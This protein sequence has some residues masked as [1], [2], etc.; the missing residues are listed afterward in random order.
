MKIRF[1]SIVLFGVLHGVCFSDTPG[2]PRAVFVEKTFNFGNVKQGVEVTHKF[3]VKNEG[4]AP[5]LLDRIDFDLPGLTAKFKPEIPPGG[6][7]FIQVDWNTTSFS[8]PIDLE[9]KLSS[10]DPVRPK[11]TFTL[12]GSI[13][14]VIEVAP[15]WGGFISLYADEKKEQT[16]HIINHE[17]HPL[18][19]SSV[20]K[21]G[22]HFTASLK[23]V[24]SGKSY[25]L[26]ITVPAG[27]PPGHYE[28]A[29]LLHTNHPKFSEVPVG[30]N[31][32]VMRDVHAFPESVDLKGIDLSILNQNPK[33]IDNL[34]ENVIVENRRGDF[35]IKSIQTDVPF[36]KITQAPPSGRSS[37]F[38]LDIQV[39]KEKLAPGK[40]SGSIRVATDVKEFPEITIPVVAEIK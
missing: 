34:F 10:N 24:Q 2:A 3:Q 28:E 18:K 30:I 32:L 29:L 22:A 35:E 20:E 8:G 6:E 27:T 11:F 36:L 40:I 31:V 5:L 13:D 14:P 12:S 37:R 15:I 9:A 16:L 7:G 38:K 39:L 21:Q 33:L 17:Q 4:T 25:D 26:T 19:I 23:E 1:T